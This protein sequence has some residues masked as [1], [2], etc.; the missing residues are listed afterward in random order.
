MFSVN[1]WIVLV[2]EFTQTIDEVFNSPVPPGKSSRQ[3][4]AI[5]VRPITPSALA[6][7]YPFSC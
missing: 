4:Q 3:N 7:I 1:V 5:Q 2:A 6:A